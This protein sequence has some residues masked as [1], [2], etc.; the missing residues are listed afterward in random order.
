[1]FIA[2]YVNNRS[3]SSQTFM[4]DPFITDPFITDHVPCRRCSLQI[5]LTTDHVHNRPRL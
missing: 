3:H 5:I 2:D 1:M 4:T